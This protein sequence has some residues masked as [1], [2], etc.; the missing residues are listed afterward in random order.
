MTQLQSREDYE[1]YTAAFNARDY[2]AVFDFYAERPRMEFFGVKITSRNELKAFYSFLHRFVKET[3]LV[4][5][6]AVS[7]DLA[8]VEGIVRIEGIQ[9]LT[10]EELDDHGLQAFFPIRQG[11]IQEMR[12]YIHYHLKD[13]KIERVGCAL[14]P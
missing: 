7:E 12:Q 9:D 11:D 10:R 13:G 8:A 3:V 14:V 1:R 2:D 6:F 5:R 4:E